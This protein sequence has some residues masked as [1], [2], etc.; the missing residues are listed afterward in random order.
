MRTS[1]LLLLAALPGTSWAI[2]PTP[3]AKEDAKRFSAYHGPRRHA[4]AA[5]RDKAAWDFNHRRALSPSAVGQAFARGGLEPKTAAVSFLREARA[6]LGIDPDSLRLEREAAAAGHKHLL[7]RQAYRGLPVEFAYVKVHLADNGAVLG[8][9]S[10]YERGLTLGVVPAVSAAQAASAVRAAGLKPGAEASLVVLPDPS[11]GPARLAWSLTAEGA[12]GRWRYYVDGL[13]G[14]VLFR[15]SLLRNI[16][17]SSGKMSAMIYDIDPLSGTPQTRPLANMRVFQQNASNFADTDLNGNYCGAA[18]GKVFTQFQGPFVRVSNFRGPSAHYDNGSGV[19]STVATPVSSPHPYPASSVVVSTIDLRGVIPPDAVKVLPVFSSFRVGEISAV[20]GFGEGGDVTDD[21]QLTILDSSGSPVASYLGNRG[22]FNAAAV[23]GQVMYLKLKA[24]DQ[25]SGETGYDVSLSSY[26][27]LSNPALD[28]PGK[29][30]VW[31]ASHTYAGLRSEFNLFFH[32]NEMHDF[33]MFGTAT[34]ALGNGISLYGNDLLGAQLPGVDISSAAFI[35]K[36][37][38]ALALVGPNIGNPFYD[39]DYDDIIFGDISDSNPTDILTDDATVPHHEYTH[40]VV[41]K[42]WSLQNFGEAGAISE[43]N[44]DYFSAS[45]LDHSAIGTYVVQSLG[46]GGLPIR[47]LDSA[48]GADTCGASPAVLGPTTWQ[49]EIHCDSRFFSQALWDIRKA[50]VG[51]QGLAPGRACVDGLVFQSLLFFPESFAEFLA[52]MLKVDSLGLV[53][54]CA[55]NACGGNALSCVQT[56]INAAFNA[57]G[58]QSVGGTND[59]YDTVTSRNDGFESAVDVTTISAVSATIFPAGDSDFF[60]FPAGNGPVSITMTLPA[61]GS[62]PGLFKAYML[63]LY[64]TDH[65]QVAQAIPPLD[66]IN[67]VGG[68]CADTDCTSSASSVLLN[69]IPPKGTQLYLEVTGGPTASGGSNSGVNST[70]AYGLQIQ[71]QPSGAISGQIVTAA[72]DHDTV[73]F[74][75]HVTTWPFRQDYRFAH[76]QLRDQGNAIVPGTVT[77]DTHQ[78]GDWLD[79]VSSS[80]ALGQVSGAL[81]LHTGFAARFPALG[82]VSLEVFGYNVLGSTISL[83]LSRPFNLTTNQ[84]ALTAFNNVFNP[85]MG[86]KTTIKYEVQQG[87]HIT[88]RLYSV[89]GTFVAT[90]LDTEITAGKGSVDWNAVNANGRVVASGVYILYMR[91]PGISKTQKIVVV[92]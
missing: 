41:E 33:F 6:R 17:G 57:H 65:R 15:H 39:P 28:A 4:D 56:T 19:W 54:A 42:I 85:N 45:S 31:L 75:V 44:A 10:N 68:F 14:A 8:V 29:D 67:T 76:A 63:T 71:Y 18:I 40:Y 55:V 30:L 9:D 82:T 47:Q 53:P 26:L 2:M 84:T 58:L 74:K 89:D 87:G 21:D 49:G 32:L 23:P 5:E 80:N 20:T 72:F 59:P 60:T 90:L 48:L 77:H 1:A 37:M 64:D 46:G 11:G 52:A 51:L 73:S 43:G 62:N 79:F 86:Q 24:N 88:L 34:N 16:C 27:T 83:G 7:Y 66:G 35:G 12:G 91:G 61:D 50:R 3:Q 36:P 70:V 13:T 25:A 81:Q 38:H 92:K 78:A 69:Y 22:G